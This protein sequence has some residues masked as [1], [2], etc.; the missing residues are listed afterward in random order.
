MANYVCEIALIEGALS[1]A[2]VTTFP[3]AGALAEFRG[4]VRPFE[5]D[6]AINGIQYEANRPMAE[7]QLRSVAEEAAERFEL[8]SIVLHHRVGFVPA[9][10]SSLLLRVASPHR[11]AALASMSWAIDELKKRV[12]IW[13]KAENVSAESGVRR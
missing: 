10:E 5:A 6:E 4:N 8:L 9:G 13:K 11:A 1:D 2:A 3:G 12:P 7:H